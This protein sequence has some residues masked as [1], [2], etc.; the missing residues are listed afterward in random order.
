M[1]FVARLLA[2]AMSIAATSMAVRADPLYPT[3]PVQSLKTYAVEL[4]HFPKGGW[5]GNGVYLGN[6]RVLT[7]AHVAGS[8]WQIERVQIA[9]QS[10]PMSVVK[11]GSFGG[12]DLAL[13]SIDDAKLPVSLRLRRLS[14]CQDEPRPGESVTVATPQSVAPSHIIA[15]ALLPR[16]LAPKYWTAISDV[17]TTGNSGSGVFDSFKE[18]LLGIISGKI[19]GEQVG[20]AS[21][22]LKPVKRDIA[23]FFVPA[24]LIAAFLPPQPSEG[25]QSR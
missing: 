14:L 15:P 24:S 8:F 11:R 12:V 16:N 1:S 5:A 23:K 3:V 17:A 13:L 9:G 18:C 20:H 7:A 21:V 6:G 10:L 19:S 22:N 4:V 2:L 25:M